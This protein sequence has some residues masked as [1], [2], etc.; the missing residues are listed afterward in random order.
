MEVEID[1][2]ELEKEKAD[3]YFSFTYEMFPEVEPGFLESKC[4]Q[5]AFDQE[6]FNN[7]VMETMLQNKYPKQQPCTSQ[8]PVVNK[9]EFT[10][11]G[12]TQKYPD[13]QKYFLESKYG[14]E[15]IAHSISFLQDRYNNL[16]L[17]IM[18][19]VMA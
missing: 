15:Y 19:F 17:F 10:V 3:S 1:L 4:I 6:G 16:F 8:A 9:N 13:P 2:D 11:E 18:Y 5:Y 14:S 12:F 7:F